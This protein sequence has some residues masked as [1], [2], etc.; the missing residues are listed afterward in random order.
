M[1]HY[2][3]NPQGRF[4]NIDQQW[5]EEMSRNR[6]EDIYGDQ[7]YYEDNYRN[8]YKPPFPMPDAGQQR[9]Q[10]ETETEDRGDYGREGHYGRTYDQGGRN[11]RGNLGFGENYRRLEERGEDDGRGGWWQ[12]EDSKGP[13]YSSTM[14]KFGQI[15]PYKGKGPRGYERSDERVREDISDRLCDDP[16]IDASDIEVS[17]KNCEVTLSGTVADR[18]AKRHAEEI[19]ESV[20]GV[21]NA[22]NRLRVKTQNENPGQ[23]TR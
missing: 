3:R 14:R 12:K 23:R 20:S 2:K 17:V 11:R 10:G 8:P 7:K 16:S 4:R 21:K 5:N 13:G 9:R 18:Y 19:A 15:G 1:S 6:K 22:E